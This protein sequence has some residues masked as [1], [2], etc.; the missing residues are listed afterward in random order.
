MRGAR[1]GGLR[2]ARDLDPVRQQQADDVRGRAGV[3]PRHDHDA[4]HAVGRGFHQGGPSELVVVEQAVAPVLRRGLERGEGGDE[5][6]RDPVAEGGDRAVVTPLVELG[7]AVGLVG[8]SRRALEGR[9]LVP[10]AHVEEVEHAAHEVLP[11]EAVERRRVAATV[12]IEP[13]RRLRGE[14]AVDRLR[15][16][17]EEERGRRGMVVDEHLRPPPHH[18]GHHGA[19]FGLALR[20]QTL[21]FFRRRNRPAIALGPQR[22][23]HELAE[24]EA[25][26]LSLCVGADNAQRQDGLRLLRVAAVELEGAVAGAG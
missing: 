1:S 26:G 8:H 3:R 2:E 21:R 11:A 12:R 4:L 5:V 18:A 23:Q 14:V 24:E 7:A 19:Y 22:P 15:H 9:P 20:E 16:G 6:V 25:L 13:L 10:V 17:R